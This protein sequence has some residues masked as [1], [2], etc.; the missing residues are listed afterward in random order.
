MDETGRLDAMARAI[1][2]DRLSQRVVSGIEGT[3]KTFT[4]RSHLRLG[5]G[6]A[7]R[8]EVVGL[9]CGDGVLREGG[10]AGFPRVQLRRRRTLAAA[11]LA[12]ARVF[13]LSKAGQQA[14]TI[15]LH[16][17]RILL[18]TEK[19][20]FHRVPV[21]SGKLLDVVVTCPQRSQA[22]FLREIGEVRI[23]KQRGM[24][25]QRSNSIEVLSS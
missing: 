13:Q 24:S 18:V 11:V 5:I 3:R 20:E 17:G 21:A 15:G 19:A 14:R 16:L 9:I 22:D 8:H 25:V 2:P 7:L 4:E 6:K 12:R 23:G 10:D 1:H